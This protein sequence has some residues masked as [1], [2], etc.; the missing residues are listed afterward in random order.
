MP[1]IDSLRLTP[2]GAI[3]G[4]LHVTGSHPKD[5]VITYLAAKNWNAS[6]IALAFDTLVAESCIRVDAD[7]RA[8]FVRL[9]SSDN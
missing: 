1:A 8:H 9:P 2:R 3:L 4:Y 7:G 5:D 6:M